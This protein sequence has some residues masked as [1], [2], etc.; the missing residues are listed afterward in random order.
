MVIPAGNH[1]I[2][3]DFHPKGYFTGNK[4]AL[5]SSI[6]LV[7]MALGILFAEFRPKRKKENE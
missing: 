4:I 2:E 5:A 7:L 6:L 3:F 1:K